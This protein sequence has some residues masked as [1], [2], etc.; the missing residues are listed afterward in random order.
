MIKKI[1]SNLGP[2]EQKIYNHISSGGAWSEAHLKDIG[3]SEGRCQHCGQDVQDITH[4]TWECPE[5]N[6]HRKIKDLRDVNAD[7]LPDFIKHGIPKS[8]ST[9]V[10]GTFW[11]DRPTF[12]QMQSNEQTIDAIGMQS[13]IKRKTIASCKNQEIMDVLQSNSLNP[14]NCNARQCFQQIKACKQ[15]PHLALPYKCHRTAP[16]DINVY[17][18][19]SWINP[20]QQYLGLGGA[21]VWWP[22]RDPTVYQRLSQAEKDLAF[23]KQ[24][25]TGL[26]LYTP[27]GGF[28][29]SSTRT[30]L[31]AAIIALCANGPIHIGT[32]SQAF[33]DRAQWILTQMRK[34]KQHRTNWQ[35]TSDGDL[36]QHF[37]EAAKAKGWK[38]IRI[39][40]V[41]G[42]AT[43]QQVAEGA[44]RSCDK[45]GNDEADR[46]AD[47]AV[48]TH[49]KDVV[50]IAKIL[51]HRH[52]LYTRFMQKVVKHII[53]A[54]LIHKRLI[55]MLTSKS[56]GKPDKV[57][58]QP[59]QVQTPHNTCNPIH[60]VSLQGNIARFAKFSS[61]RKASMSVWAFLDQ[62][63]FAE[64]T[65]QFHATTW[66]E[67]YLIY[68]ARGFPKLIRDNPCKARSRATVR[69]QL[70]E[71]KNT[72]R[73][74]V[75]RGLADESQA[76]A[77]RPIKVTHDR[78]I[79]LGVKGRFP[80]INCSIVVDDALR[81]V[82]EHNLIALG[83]RISNRDIQKFYNGDL[84]LTP[85][86]PNL[87]GRVGW[88]SKLRQLPGCTVESKPI[89]DNECKQGASKR[90]ISPVCFQCPSCNASDLSSNKA[91]Q[92]KD[93][94]A[95]CKCKS[96][97]QKIKVKD[98]LC[99]CHLKWHICSTHQ[100][101]A[102]ASNA[103]TTLS[104]KPGVPKRSIGPL[105]QEQLQEIDAKRRRKIPPR[106]LPLT[107]NLLS[108]KLRER[109]AHLF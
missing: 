108:S 2:K 57:N 100:T 42:H 16:D 109:F 103:R 81:A 85:N 59:L 71:F 26:M 11:G 7:L 77:F 21:G 70:K 92:L 5:I 13:N 105:T 102:N 62:L 17:T 96:C 6:K 78:F 63:E 89:V 15:P 79:N 104:S 44:I 80:A 107:P 76:E 10:E 66:M 29:G 55:E 24:Y 91:F 64:C 14:G 3:L 27:I 93:L 75:Q 46:A 39:T 45:I 95:T 99:R 58:F 65:N 32:D 30:E 84:A 33:L 38:S 25:P 35:T 8:M 94:D 1:L 87:N 34:G 36:W 72:V 54:Y 61:K 37:E 106:V 18:D 86:I 69:M 23:C 97:K 60:K 90:P 9:D 19:G 98:W 22:G 12:E 40:K 20:L 73:G 101:Y 31:A 50:G 68:R 83:R 88:D 67:L 47:I 82:L 49:G 43:H 4:I 52:F 53:E 56:M 48:Q 28:T 74:I 51:H 41:K